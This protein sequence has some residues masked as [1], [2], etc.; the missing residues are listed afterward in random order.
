MGTSRARRCSLSCVRPS[1]CPRASARLHP[2]L[3]SQ[4]THTQSH[5]QTYDTNNNHQ[6]THH[7][8]W[9]VRYWDDRR[10]LALIRSDF[11]WFLPT[12][13][14]YR[15]VR[16]H[17]GVVVERVEWAVWRSAFVK[18]GAVLC[19]RAA[20]VC[21]ACG[22]SQH[23]HNTPSLSLFSAPLSFLSLSLSRARP[24]QVVQRSD[25]A[26]WLILYTHG[27]VYI[28]NGEGAWAWAVW[29]WRLGDG[30][31]A[32]PCCAA[33]CVHCQRRP[34]QAPTCNNTNN[35]NNNTNNKT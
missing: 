16:G 25:A 18:G 24:P 32:A 4:H 34:C 13:R 10:V 23:T 33:L 21:G 35:T 26:R 27:G 17:R 11:P 5:T 6:Q 14:G 12:Y 19:A 15:Q 9:E 3:A 7:P 28:D 2:H 8:G 20:C 22:A 30:I 29:R 1:P 31:V